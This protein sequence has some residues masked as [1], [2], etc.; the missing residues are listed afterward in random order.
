MLDIFSDLP[1]SV[2]DELS[3]PRICSCPKFPSHLFQTTEIDREVFK[4]GRAMTKDI[5]AG[6]HCILLP[7]KQR[8]VVF[9][10]ARRRDCLQ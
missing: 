9:G 5:V 6:K 1:W 10:V 2:F 4:N 3:M 8:Y 7:Q